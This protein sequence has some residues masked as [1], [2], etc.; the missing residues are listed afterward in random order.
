MANHW[1]GGLLGRDLQALLVRRGETVTG[2]A[3]GDLDLTDHRAIGAAMRMYQPEVVVNCAAWTAVDEAED[4]EDEALAVNGSGVVA[5]ARACRSA[6][7]QLVHLST[8]YV[9]GDPCCPA[10]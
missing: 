4:R 9:F 6:G 7:S 2:L 8:D 1:R 5:L 10:L 3:R